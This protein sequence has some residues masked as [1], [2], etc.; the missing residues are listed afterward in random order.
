[1]NSS[2][3]ISF[4]RVLVLIA[5]LMNAGAAAGA[6][7]AAPQTTLPPVRLTTA[8]VRQ[9][10]HVYY[11]TPDAAL[12]LQLFLPPTGTRA[13]RAGI[14]F[15]HGGGGTPKDRATQFFP[16]GEYFAS[17]GMVCAAVEYPV[18]RVDDQIVRLD[19][20]MAQAKAAVRWL[21]A[22]AREFGLD[23]NKIVAAGGSL[24]GMLALQTALVPGFDS[25]DADPAVSCV[26]NALVL[27]NPSVQIR[28]LANAKGEPIGEKIAPALFQKKNA[29][30]AIFF[31][32]T[33]D[34]LNELGLK[35]IAESRAL[36]NRCDYF[37]AHE[38]RHGF[39]NREPWTTATALEVDRF[40]VSIGFLSGKPTL[41]PATATLTEL[42]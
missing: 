41:S 7:P 9:E 6:E 35:F 15:F 39:F 24:G 22:R 34:S 33:L 36:G 11:T 21:R 31:Y 42:K 16:Q 5:L 13:K 20:S 4:P 30:P 2:M 29:P 27:F 26:P 1:M 12:K 3:T 32:G 28:T 10:T 17:R 40:L 23:E 18:I 37:T 38:Q 19:E 14:V 8:A 25:P